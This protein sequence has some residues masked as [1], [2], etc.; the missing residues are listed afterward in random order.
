MNYIEV[1]RQNTG[2]STVL[3]LDEVDATSTSEIGPIVVPM[4]GRISRVSAQLVSGD[5]STIRPEFGAKAGWTD[6]TAEEI[7]SGIGAVA[8]SYISDATPYTYYSEH[9]ELYI[10]SGVDT[11]TNNTIRYT[12]VIEKI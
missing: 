6:R 8:S 12:I 1:S 7:S 4:A 5:G 2:G 10:R 3:I 9:G 11:G